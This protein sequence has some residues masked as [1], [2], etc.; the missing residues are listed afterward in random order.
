MIPPQV[1]FLGSFAITVRVTL[2]AYLHKMKFEEQ[3]LD[4]YGPAQVGFGGN[5][6]PPL[7][8]MLI[9]KGLRATRFVSPAAHAEYE[10]RQ[11]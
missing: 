4:Q 8:L 2:A 6:L 3:F 7:R 9:V 10:Y 11:R 5:Y 1:L